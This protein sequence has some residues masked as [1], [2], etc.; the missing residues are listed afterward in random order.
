MPKKAE[1]ISS[2]SENKSEEKTRSSQ[3]PHSKSSPSERRDAFSGSA[4]GEAG[5]DATPLSDATFRRGSGPRPSDAEVREAGRVMGY[6]ET[7][8]EKFLA[9]MTAADWVFVNASG[10]TVPIG[11]RNLRTIMQ[12]WHSAEIRNAARD[13]Q[14]AKG[15]RGGA[16]RSDD[17]IGVRWTAEDM[18]AKIKRMEQLDND[19]TS[20]FRHY[21]LSSLKSALSETKR[22]ADCSFDEL[23][24]FYAKHPGHLRRKC[25]GC[26]V[27]PGTNGMFRYE[28]DDGTYTDSRLDWYEYRLEIDRGFDEWEAK[29]LASAYGGLKP[30]EAK[31]EY[32]R[33]RQALRVVGDRIRAS[34]PPFVPPEPSKDTPWTAETPQ[35]AQKRPATAS[36]QS[37]LDNDTPRVPDAPE[38]RFCSSHETPPVNGQTE[39]A[40][41]PTLPDGV[42]LDP[43]RPQNLPVPTREEAFAACREAGKGD[44]FCAWFWEFVCSHGFVYE[45]KN[46]VWNISTQGLPFA[47]QMLEK[48]EWRPLHP[49]PE[50][51]PQNVAS[52]DGEETSDDGNAD[53]DDENAGSG[54]EEEKS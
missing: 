23:V 39:N 26:S 13:A 53:F 33:R 28:Y 20:E 29:H 21:D 45:Y 3:D 14:A 31:S 15:G 8:T 42:S 37:D 16:R 7:F 18:A 19:P 4:V 2:P 30:N 43:R 52:A 51:E 25:I 47:V 22:E 32:L 41:K 27:L 5:L 36:G 38:G 17:P 6:P 9:D 46:R 1:N 12:R 44:D 50:S 10:V 40:T 24:E 11:R 49:E 34:R 54:D 35:N 48:A